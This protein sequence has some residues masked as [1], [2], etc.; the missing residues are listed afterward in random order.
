MAFA[1]LK[2]AKVPLQQTFQQTLKQVSKLD[3]RVALVTG[4]SGAIGGA[5]AAALI[6]EGATVVISGRREEHLR[7]QAELLGAE[8]IPADVTKEASVE[9]LF[10]KMATLYGGCDLLVNC[11]GVSIGGAVTELSED[12][13]SRSLA[14]NVTGPFLCAREAF[15]QMEPK[16]GGR[17]VNVGSIAALSP[18][19]DSAP[20]TTSKFAL[21][22]LTMTLALDGRERNIAVGVVHPGNVPSELFSKD[23][24]ERREKTEGFIQP[25]DVAECVLT[26][27]GLPLSAN[28]LELSVLPTRQPLIGRG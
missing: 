3:G 5:I 12:Q 24:I 21:Q 8:A 7:S 19:P 1:A 23:E 4:G 9:E 27:C 28:V 6:R 15:K 14:V 17:I 13:M 18:R 26:M 22:G 20:Y 25:Q 2:S 16:G 10:G 11:A